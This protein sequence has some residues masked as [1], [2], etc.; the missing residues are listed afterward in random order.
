MLQTSDLNIQ[1]LQDV[2]STFNQ[3]S[4]DLQKSYEELE[5]QVANL[6]L[7]LATARSARLRDLKAKEQLANKLSSLMKSLPGGILVINNNH[8]VIEENQ[9]AIDLLGGSLLDH[10]WSTIH[11]KATSQDE[12]PGF[13]GEFTLSNNRSIS[14]TSSDYGDQGDKILLITDVTET[15]AL[16]K[17]VNRDK[18]LRAMGEMAARLAHQ[19]RTPLSTAILYLSNLNT[20]KEDSTES[21]HYIHKI[22]GKLGHIEK[23]V[24][25]MLQ[26][27]NEGINTTE[28]L[29]LNK[30]LKDV[31]CTINERLKNSDSQITY[32]GID[33]DTIIRGNPM[34]LENATLNLVE[35][36]LAAISTRAEI[37]IGLDK[38]DNQ[39]VFS[40]EDN[41]PGIAPELREQ[42]FD[43]FFS[44]KNQGTGLG[45]A[46]VLSVIKAHG[47]DIQI[48]DS[49]LGGA[50]FLVH[51]P[52]NQYQELDN[53]G[54]WESQTD[55]LGSRL[56]E[57]AD[58]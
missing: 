23:L 38:I 8:V 33:E 16:N 1:N 48:S 19:I 56:K 36:A 22:H 11:K 43:P 49:S 30:L 24:T 51:L 37:K 35:N 32:Q 39:F 27:I 18:R 40:I 25:G 15:V 12:M 47:G 54:L 29:S 6:N 17:Q 42:I 10:P 45:L 28:T 50:K 5:G 2:F 20:R 4:T 13:S 31:T 44:T 3:V 41:G 9:A 14:V 7:E 26:Y 34:A 46:I 52:D 55:S 57:A 53:T 21:G 58:E